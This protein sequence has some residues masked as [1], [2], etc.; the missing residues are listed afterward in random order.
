MNF[1]LTPKADLLFRCLAMLH[2]FLSHAILY[3]YLCV[4]QIDIRE[5]PYIVRRR[6]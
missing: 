5:K 6:S 3:I 2:V 4:G 1:W